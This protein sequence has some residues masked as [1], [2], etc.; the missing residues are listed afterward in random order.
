M[1]YSKRMLKH[2]KNYKSIYIVIILLILIG[3]FLYKYPPN[4]IVD[5]IGVENIYTATFIISLT[6]GLSS[7]TS[8]VFYTAIVTFAS[9]GTSHWVLGL[10]GG[11]GLFIG[12]SIIFGLFKFGF[13]KTESKHKERIKKMG[14]YLEKY[15]NW[16][17]YIGLF[18]ILGITPFPNDI[19]MFGL[20]LFGFKY[21][22][23]FP[24]I[25][26]ACIS[27]VTITALLGQSISTFLLG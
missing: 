8:G 6:S 2:L 7:V 24:I 10:I 4:Q 21:V 1:R 25:L 12:D 9:G 16:V 13:K 3:L 22:K 20:V 27:I 18:L 19:I 26:L 17:M 14:E 11:L 5:W 23:V 15:P